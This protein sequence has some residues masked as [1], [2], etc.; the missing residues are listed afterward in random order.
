MTADDYLAQAKHVAL[1]A[2]AIEAAEDR[3]SMLDY[4]RR[5]RA[6]AEA[7]V[8]PKAQSTGARHRPE[9]AKSFSR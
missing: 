9:E 1:V 5:L 2:R 3:R 7:R 6:R 4:A 8:Q